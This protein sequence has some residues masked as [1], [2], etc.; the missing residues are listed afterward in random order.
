MHY[1][2]ICSAFRTTFSSFIY[3]Y[4]F[5][6][7][8]SIQM[9]KTVIITGGYLARSRVQEYDLDGAT[10]SDLPDLIW[11]RHDHAC[12]HYVHNGKT[13][14]WLQ[15][16][17]FIIHTICFRSLLLVEGMVNMIFSTPQKFWGWKKDNLQDVCKHPVCGRKHY[18]IFQVP[19]AIF[20]VSI[21]EIF[22]L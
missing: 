18:R 8:C 22:F 9:E 13:V 20:M 7:A 14:I 15:N 3:F 17:N 10:E 16:Y 11:G 12:G 6:S 5:S 4:F 19:E 21:L 2:F 1:T